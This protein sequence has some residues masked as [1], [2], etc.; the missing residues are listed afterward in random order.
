MSAAAIAKLAVTVAPFARE[1][2]PYVLFV[3][4]ADS[5]RLNAAMCTS[6]EAKLMHHH[7]RLVDPGPC[8]SP[9]EL[10]QELDAITGIAQVR[11]KDRFVM[12]RLYSLNNHSTCDRVTPEMV[13]Y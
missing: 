6:L 3:H 9:G 2:Q 5:S 12:T 10:R 11:P 8:S 13:F 4:A 7:R 1:L